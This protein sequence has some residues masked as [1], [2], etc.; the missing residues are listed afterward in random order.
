V[1]G[2]H[3]CRALPLQRGGQRVRVGGGVIYVFAG[4]ELDTDTELRRDGSVVS[5]E[6]QVYDVL[7]LTRC[8][9]G[10]RLIGPPGP[11]WT[12]RTSSGFSP[13]RPFGRA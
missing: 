10:S 7:V 6:P 12:S 1:C 11:A 3:P 2:A 9:P 4:C 13:T 8:A 5:I